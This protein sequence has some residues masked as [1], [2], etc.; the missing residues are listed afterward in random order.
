M[1]TGGHGSSEALEELIESE[2][3]WPKP[4]AV[5]LAPTRT[6]TYIAIQSKAHRFFSSLHFEPVHLTVTG[7][8]FWPSQH[9]RESK[10]CGSI[11]N[12]EPLPSFGVSWDSKV[13][14]HD[15]K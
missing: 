12:V 13:D 5:I 9:R 2:P 10:F 8:Q 3:R 6:Y 7:N 14:V 11:T 15:R 4:H 1:H